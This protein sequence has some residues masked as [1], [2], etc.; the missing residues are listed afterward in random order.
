MA[1][2]SV[3][4]IARGEVAVMSGSFRAVASKQTPDAEGTRDQE[5]SRSRSAPSRRPR[6][7]TEV[8]RA[9]SLAARQPSL[10]EGEHVEVAR[11][12]GPG[13]A[14]EDVCVGADQDP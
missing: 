10:Q 5:Q 6:R 3:G 1:R 8:Q 14:V 4:R 11:R 13:Q 7:A 12:Q 9:G 2:K